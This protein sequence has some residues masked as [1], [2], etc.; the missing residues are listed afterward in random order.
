MAGYR[1]NHAA[2]AGGPELHQLHDVRVEHRPFG[3][4]LA[5]QKE[6]TVAGHPFRRPRVDDMAGGEL[7]C[8]GL[9]LPALR[10]LGDV[11]RRGS[12]RKLGPARV[13]QQRLRVVVEGAGPN[14]LIP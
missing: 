3:P 4:D 14:G 2:A 6:L 12:Q 11:L 9:D 1:R 13:V 7:A 8:S 5:A 10:G